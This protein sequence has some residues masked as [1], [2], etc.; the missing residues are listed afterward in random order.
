M[1]LKSIEKYHDLTHILIYTN[2]TENCELVKKYI[3]DILELNIININKENYYNEALHSKSNKNLNDIKLSEGELT[4]FKKAS[5]GIIS[6]VYIFGE[7][8][9]CPKLNGVVFGENMD[10]DI[11]IV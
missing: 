6:S 4:K 1:S 3:D 9:D 8:F 10:S 2:K 7:G 11:R 5:W